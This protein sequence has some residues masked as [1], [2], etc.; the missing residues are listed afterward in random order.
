[1]SRVSVLTCSREVL[2]AGGANYGPVDVLG[3]L[4]EVLHLIHVVED[5]SD[6]RQQKKPDDVRRLSSRVC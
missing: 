4:Q 6:H 3:L 2:E 1:M 5:I